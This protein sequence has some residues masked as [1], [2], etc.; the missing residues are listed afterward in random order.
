MGRTD[1]WFY[2]TKCNWGGKPYELKDGCCP[3]CGGR[4]T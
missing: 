4:I 2:C 3:R 1:S